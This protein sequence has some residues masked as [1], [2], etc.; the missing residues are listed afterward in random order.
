MYPIG[1]RC[2]DHSPAALAGRPEAGGS[3]RGL[4]A[5]D[6]RSVL[7]AALGF[8]AR[9]W[10]VFPLRMNDK[11]PAFP[12]HAIDRC[13]GRDPRCR[14]AG[15]HVGWEERATTDP[16]RIRRAWSTRPYNIGIACGPSNLVVIDLDTRKP[17]KDTPPPEWAV[18][19]PLTGRDTFAL[20]CQRTGQPAPW[21]TFTVTTTSGGTHLFLQHPEDGPRLRNSC[22]DQGNGLGWL[23]DT[24]AHGGY[25]VAAGSVVAGKPYTITLDRQPAPLPAW[26]AERLAPRPVA[27]RRPIVVKLR[28]GRSGTFLDKAITASLTAIEAAG[29]NGTLNATLY[30]ASVALGQLVAGGALGETE[31]ETLLLNAA[32]SAGHPPAGARR[33]IRSG[34]RAGSSRPRGVAA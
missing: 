11:R 8:A 4:P 19:N 28:T 21:D 18:E 15:R 24:R 16:D 26:L 33:T 10:H 25:V 7:T 31:T 23:V 20:V 12:D 34:F 27:P 14:A 2:P 22:G 29:N 3:A 5:V 1:F 6:T 30:G 17:G 13:T 32:V 9:G